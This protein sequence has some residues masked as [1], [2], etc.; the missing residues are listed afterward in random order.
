MKSDL[1]T[2]ESTPA[3]KGCYDSLLCFGVTR[4][5]PFRRKGSY[6][7]NHYKKASTPAVRLEGINRRLNLSFSSCQP[8]PQPTR[9]S[10]EAENLRRSHSD[11]A[12]Y[13][14]RRF[15]CTPNRSVLPDQT[16]ESIPGPDELYPDFSFP[17]Q[18][19]EGRRPIEPR[20]AKVRNLRRSESEVTY[21]Q[22]KHW[23]REVPVA[24]NFHPQFYSPPV[25]GRRIA[26]IRKKFMKPNEQNLYNAGIEKI[27]KKT[28]KSRPNAECPLGINK[29][30][31]NDQF[32]GNGSVKNIDKNRSHSD[33]TVVQSNSHYSNPIN[34]DNPNDNG[35]PVD[36][37]SCVAMKDLWYNKLS[38]VIAEERDKEPSTTTIQVTHYD[39]LS[40]TDIVSSFVCFYTF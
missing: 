10:M 17:S 12:Y 22:H 3:S 2:L 34:H 8:S 40:N 23:R 37:Y 24:T 31:C 5:P 25:R 13:A 15:R 20:M 1:F 19:K 39:P 14:S 27:N 28:N 36:H 18:P 4:S 21:S 16:Y 26:Q 11:K 32:P 38:Q 35:S 6:I 29:T 30:N 7:P 33:K 9:S